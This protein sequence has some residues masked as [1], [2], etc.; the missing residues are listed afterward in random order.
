MGHFTWEPLCG[1]ICMGA[2]AWDPFYASSTLP[3]DERKGPTSALPG[4]RQDLRDELGQ[5][6]VDGFELKDIDKKAVA[7][8]TQYKD[9]ACHWYMKF[10]SVPVPT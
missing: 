1:C 8:P 2:S 10:S 4:V 9:D 7:A 5:V 3:E 6:E